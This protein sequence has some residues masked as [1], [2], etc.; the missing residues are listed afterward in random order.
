MSA[1]DYLP[2][3]FAWGVFGLSMLGI[4]AWILASFFFVI[5]AHP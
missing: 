4:V 5:T 3:D 1:K 2:Q